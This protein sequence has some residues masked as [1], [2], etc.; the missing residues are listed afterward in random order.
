MFCLGLANLLVLFF[1]FQFLIYSVS[2]MYIEDSG[3]PHTIEF[4]LYSKRVGSSFYKCYHVFVIATTAKIYFFVLHHLMRRPEFI[5][6]EKVIH[7]ST[8][9]P[10]ILDFQPSDTA[11]YI[12]CITFLLVLLDTLICLYITYSVRGTHPV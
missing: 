10:F 5:Y 1:I 4:Q 7:P 6:A 8:N 3:S 2:L 9:I 11:L 12:T